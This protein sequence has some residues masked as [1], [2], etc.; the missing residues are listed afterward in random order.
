[1][2]LNIK[3]QGAG[4][5]IQGVRP[6]TLDLYEFGLRLFEKGELS[7]SRQRQEAQ[8]KTPRT[9]LTPRSHQS[10]SN[11]IVGAKQHSLELQT[12]YIQELLWSRSFEQREGCKGTDSGCSFLKEAVNCWKDEERQQQYEGGSLGSPKLSYSFKRTED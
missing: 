2:S 4:T 5:G 1:M 8:F 7:T 11:N 12:A 10:S 9:K 6:L 3:V